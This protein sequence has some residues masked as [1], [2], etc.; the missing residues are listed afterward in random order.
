V[1]TGVIVD[2]MIGRVALAR[3]VNM[4]C[5]AAVCTPWDVDELPDEI[6]DAI[7]AYARAL[8]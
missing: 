8:R 1:K 2:E 3:N 7:M 5:G 4:V 6:L